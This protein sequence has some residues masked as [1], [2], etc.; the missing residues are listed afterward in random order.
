MSFNIMNQMNTQQ[1]QFAQLS[2]MNQSKDRPKFRPIR[3]GHLLDYV[4]T[5]PWRTLKNY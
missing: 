5:N 4:K 1:P 2:S 3:Q